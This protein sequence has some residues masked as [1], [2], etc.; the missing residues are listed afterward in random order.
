MQRLRYSEQG[1]PNPIRSLAAD[2]SEGALQLIN[3]GR[4]TGIKLNQW[5][6]VILNVLMDVSDRSGP[7]RAGHSFVFCMC[8]SYPP[9]F[10]LNAKS[11]LSVLVIFIPHL[12]LQPFPS[13]LILL[14]S[15]KSCCFT[16]SLS[17]VTEEEK[18]LFYER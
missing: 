18:N 9:S 6:L 2:G 13:Y 10:F 5:L 11:I 8:V 4:S 14:S 17:S 1:R 15:L 7:Q 12:P 3:N 16:A